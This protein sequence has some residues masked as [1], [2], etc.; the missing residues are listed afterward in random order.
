MQ[1]QLD[2]E[3]SY[4]F[5]LD[6]DADGVMIIYVCNNVGV[7]YSVIWNIPNSDVS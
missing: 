2:L 4:S 7:V 5:Y 6:A 1:F 3:V